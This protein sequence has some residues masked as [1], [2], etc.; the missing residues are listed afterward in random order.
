MKGPEHIEKRTHVEVDG[1]CARRSGEFKAVEE[2]GKPA[3]KP[4][5]ETLKGPVKFFIA[6]YVVQGISLHFGL[7][8]QP[9]QYFLMKHEGL[10][11]SD[12]A[13]YVSLLMVPWIIK[14][15]YAILTDF[16]RFGG[17]RRRS[18]LLTA[19]A[20][21]GLAMLTIPLT[22]SAPVIVGLLVLAGIGLAFSNVV[23]NGLTVEACLKNP[24]LR[25]LW[26]TQSL[27]Y[28]TANIACLALGGVLCQRI[29]AEHAVDYA[30]AMAG[31]MPLLFLFMVL[32][33]VREKGE[34]L[35]P[36]KWAEAKSALVQCVRTPAY[37]SIAAYMLL[38]NFNVLTG[39]PLYFYESNVLQFGQS[40][41]GQ[42]NAC[43]AFGMLCG[44]LSFKLVAEKL[45]SSRTQ[46]LVTA[47]AS[48]LAMLS[49]LLLT[50]DVTG[51]SVIHFANGM[52][53]TA[54]T[55][56]IYGAASSVCSPR[57][58]ATAFSIL[59]ATF[60][61]SQQWGGMA[62]GYLYTN[63]VGGQLLPLAV[64]SALVYATCAGLVLIAPARQR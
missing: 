1:I 33:A 56:A 22:S 57:V 63:V 19:S 14:P 62:G 31:V 53:I 45:W 36:L 64:I 9:L 20:V 4:T 35:P 61:M 27:S 16:V 43:G 13:F 52:T 55:L 26:S 2:P 24:A 51:A 6:A 25:S 7:V 59:I 34:T 50:S 17:Y 39:V 12:V 49:Y 8:S 15:I 42:L 30:A 41:I 44:A 18:Y 58:E 60:N 46:L 48:S 28:F 38:F 47:I 32:H 29:G 21:A 54:A 11:A 5:G 40:T 23:M 3:E 37:L 10:P